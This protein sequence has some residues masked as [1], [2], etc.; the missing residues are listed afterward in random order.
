MCGTDIPE[1]CKLDIDSHEWFVAVAE[2]CEWG[3][4]GTTGQLHPVD[5]IERP[6]HYVGLGAAKTTQNENY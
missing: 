2:R 1:S 6:R 3:G 4:E 5:A